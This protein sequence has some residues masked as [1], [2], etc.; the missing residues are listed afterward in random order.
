M[1]N[2][3]LFY[4][5]CFFQFAIGFNLVFPLLLFLLWKVTRQELSSKQVLNQETDYAIIVT[6]YE[7][8]DLLPK[9]VDSIFSLNYQNYHVYIVADNCAENSVNIKDDRVTVLYPSVVL[10][11][12]T[13]S[14]A[15][16]MDHFIRKHDYLTII[17]SDNL[18]DKDYLNN[19]NQAVEAGY[20][21]VQGLRAPKNLDTTISALDAARDIYYH[22]YDG[23]LLFESG[24]S[25]TLSGSGMAF[26][27]ALYRNFLESNS[28][29]GAGFDKVLQFWLLKNNQRISF[30][31]NAI[32]YDEKTS[33]SQ[34]LVQQRARWINTWFKYSKFG[35]VLLFKGILSLSINRILFGVVLL[36]PPLFIFLLLSMLCIFINLMTWNIL[37]MGLWLISFMLFI[38]TFWL[39][40][41]HTNTD[42][43]IYDSLRSIPKFMCLQVLSL[44]KSRRGNEISVSTKHGKE[45]DGDISIK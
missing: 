18:V 24:S 35:F 30:V 15:Y 14:H 3:A 8:I 29:T 1:I 5:W 26:K 36:R 9:V 42:K 43:R 44:I 45:P 22:F 17:D 38:A 19:L 10:K 2:D 32:V 7:Y 12:N 13:K 23:K 21:A 37:P 20:H 16:A 25:A 4:L 40:L 28:V 33:N 27:V 6:A 11:S 34:Q 39:A 41:A 31:E